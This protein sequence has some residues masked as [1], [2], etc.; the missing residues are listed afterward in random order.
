MAQKISKLSKTHVEY[1]KHR[2]EKRSYAHHGEHRVIPEWHVRLA[3]KGV[4]KYF[5]LYTTNQAAAAY[6]AKEIWL[7][8]HSNGIEATLEK[9]KPEDT[10]VSSKKANCT[11]AEFLAEV[12][13]KSGLKP[14]TFDE[15]AKCF[16][17]IVSMINKINGKKSKF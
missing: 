4:R 16:R 8:L 6:K 12:K 15:Y 11:I 17:Q 7:F 3:Y 13:S 1:W 9:Y 14:K 2:L 10:F 5:N